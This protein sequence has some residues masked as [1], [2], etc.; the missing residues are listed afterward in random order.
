MLHFV[1]VWYIWMLLY[2]S[3]P[4][5]TLTP[6]NDINSL[7]YQHGFTSLPAWISSH[8]P[9]RVCDEISYP[10]PSF[11]RATF[12][13]WGLIFNFI[14]H[15]LMDVI[16]YPTYPYTDWSVFKSIKGAHVNCI[17]SLEI[18]NISR[19]TRRNRT[20]CTSHRIYCNNLLDLV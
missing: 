7:F 4:S 6:L 20:M 19:D 5:K 10:F 17:T 16:T 1:V 8:M 18:V 2:P 13:V 14:P 11:N 9:R 12:E 15:F 3:C